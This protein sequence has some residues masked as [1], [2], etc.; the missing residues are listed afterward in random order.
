MFS[1]Y[2]ELENYVRNNQVMM[3]DFKVTELGGKW[4]HLTIPASRLSEKIFEKGFGFDGS[5][6]G[7]AKIEQSD[8][9]FIPDLTTAFLDPFWDRKTL[10]FLGTV[11]AITDEGYIPYAGDSRRILASALE[12]MK[13]SGLADTFLVGPEYEFHIFDHVAYANEM[14][15][16]FFE[17]DSFQ[18][19]WRTGDEEGNLGFKVPLKKGYHLDAP[20][21]VNRDLRSSMAM[22]LDALDIP[23]KYHHH[24]VGGPGQH[25]IELEMNEAFRLADATMLSKYIIKNAAV[26]H[27]KTATFMPKPLHG[28]AGN[29]MHVHM[30]LW[31]DGESLFAGPDSNYAG[32]SDLALHFMG[33]ILV[34]TPALTALASPSTNS[35]KRLVRGYEAPIGIG[36]ATANRSAVLRVPGY[37][38]A[39]SSRRFEFRSSDASANPYL[40]FAGLLLAGM[41]GVARKIDPLREGY[42]PLEK[43]FYE[44]GDSDIKLLPASLEEALE[45]LEKDHDFLVKPGIFP[46]SLLENWKILKSRECASLRELP[47]PGEYALYYDC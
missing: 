15:S 2:Q 42:G 13:K 31:K 28:E 11:H 5:N 34:H 3:L 47:T 41:D 16:S 43:N 14:Q 4:R 27:G 35:Y 21:D 32:L 17:V 19:H 36:F 1:S 7:Y 33:G 37:A 18:A 9:V 12:Y 46:E 10:A 38:K 26:R 24:E 40:L 25:E 20:G 39:P 6:Y 22:L 23:V 44:L 30:Q 29:G 8:M 45:E